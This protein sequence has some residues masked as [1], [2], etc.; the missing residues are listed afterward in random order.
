MKKSTE[1]QPRRWFIRWFLS[2]SREHFTSSLCT[3]FLAIVININTYLLRL[4]VKNRLKASRREVNFF[5]FFHSQHE[6]NI[7]HGSVITFSLL[8]GFLE[9]VPAW[10]KVPLKGNFA[11]KNPREWA[12]K[13]IYLFCNSPFLMIYTTKKSQSALSF[14]SPLRENGDKYMWL[15]AR[16][17]KFIESRISAEKHFTL[18]QNS[19]DA[20]LILAFIVAIY[21]KFVSLFLNFVPRFIFHECEQKDLFRRAWFVLI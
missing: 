15:L 19:L 9:I 14:S 20:L 12:I 6:N 4:D 10:F 1:S 7:T 18:E 8:K 21:Q 17:M 5:P 11:E 2:H 16:H 3:L 13:K